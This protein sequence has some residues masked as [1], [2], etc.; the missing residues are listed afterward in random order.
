MKM[1]IPA[2][3][4]VLLLLSLSNTAHAG[5]FDGSKPV[6]C[7]VVKVIECTPEGGCREV[8]P[9][10]VAVPQ[11]LAIDFE[12]KIVSPAGKVEGD[13]SSAIKR[14]D[15]IGGKLILQGVDEG[16]QDVRDGVGWTATISEETG[17]FVLT[18]AGDQEAFI[19]YGACLPLP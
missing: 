5:D 14:M 19:V 10:S 18:A 11:F 7:S 15:R 8:T 4:A 2:S 9:E 17:R 13:R 16:I 1:S 6:L 3:I 12:K